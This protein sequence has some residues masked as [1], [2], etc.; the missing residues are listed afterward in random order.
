MTKLLFLGLFGLS[1]AC[2]GD[3]GGGDADADSDS[4]T[5]AGAAFGEPCAAD[6]DCAEA[7]CVDGAC[8]R[9]CDDYGDCPEAGHRCGESGGRDVCVPNVD[10]QVFGQNCTF[11]PCPEGY[12]CY[13]R[14]AEDPQ[15]FC[16]KACGDAGECPDGMICAGSIENPDPHCREAAFCDPCAIGD[17]CGI[18]GRCLVDDD[19]FSYCSVVCTLDTATCPAGATCVAQDSGDPACQPAAGVCGPTGELCST[20][21][22][23][24]DCDAGGYCLAD[25]LSGGVF[26]GSPC[27]LEADCPAE[28]FCNTNALLVNHETAPSGQCYPRTGDCGDPSRGGTM[29]FPCDSLAD[30]YN[31]YCLPQGFTNVC[32]E[33]CSQGGE[34]DCPPFS[35]CNEFTL[36]S[37]ESIFNCV[38][39]NGNPCYLWQQCLED[40]GAGECAESSECISGSCN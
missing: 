40:Y 17:D 36:R 38:P 16:S 8:S 37:G 14:G 9:P 13:S 1:T 39:E 35:A 4:D 18:G 20:C 31:G 5:S 22:S 28:F 24:A 33:D 10:D 34:A 6:G 27:D 30:C 19:G 32:G 29:C 12:V 11:D 15:A 3:D 7:A 23:D 26:C 2:G 21:A 25:D